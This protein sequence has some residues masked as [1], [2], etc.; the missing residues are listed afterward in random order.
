MREYFSEERLDLYLESLGM[1]N[2]GFVAELEEQARREAVPVI[3]RGTQNLLRVLLGALKPETV[4]EVGTAVGFS[5]I[6]ICSHSDARVVT[7]EKDPVRARIA[8]GNFRRAGIGERVRLLEGDAGAVLP[9]LEGPFD[10]IFLDAAKGQ[11]I[12]WFPELLRLLSRGGMLLSDNVLQEGTTLDSRY[13]VERR[14]RT[15]HRRIR[16][17]LQALAE[18]RELETTVLPVGDGLALSVRK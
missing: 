11:Y 10:L 15:I 5:C 3:R 9:G 13:A 4:L 6:Y 8:A 18:C 2:T 12:T 17:Y 14:K 1:G 16:G 7:I